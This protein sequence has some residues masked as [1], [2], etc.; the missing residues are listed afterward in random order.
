[1]RFK[2]N[3]LLFLLLLSALT[4][5]RAASDIQLSA[6]SRMAELNGIALQC[7]FVEQMQQIK[8][9]LVLN[10]PK[11]RELGL[12]FEQDTN[13]SFLRFIETDQACPQPESFSQQVNAAQLQL[14]SA[15]KE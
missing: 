9:S 3:I 5:A 15:F 11:Q 12:L 2:L 8:R 14:E 6:I 1:M 13:A 4:V 7:R 10:L